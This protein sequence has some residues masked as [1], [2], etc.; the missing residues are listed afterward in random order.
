[1][2]THRMSVARTSHFLFHFMLILYMKPKQNKCA[3][4]LEGPIRLSVGHKPTAIIRVTSFWKTGKSQGIWENL[5]KSRKRLGQS[6]W[7]EIGHRVYVSYHNDS[8]KLK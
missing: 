6:F 4:T 7:E 3:L 2:K 8:I 5:E 1:M